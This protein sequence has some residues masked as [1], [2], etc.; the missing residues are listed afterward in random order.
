[1][2]KKI[3]QRK[4]SE[5]SEIS[6]AYRS[7]N[8]EITFNTYHEVRNSMFGVRSGRTMQQNLHV[9]VVNDRHRRSLLIIAIVELGGPQV[10]IRNGDVHVIALNLVGG[11]KIVFESDATQ[12]EG[13][14]ILGLRTDGNHDKRIPH[15]DVQQNLYIPMQHNR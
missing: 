12:V 3:E 14:K 6:D 9:R 11:I 4:K 5:K 7:N 1:M 10:E 13:E 15:I 8:I 2:K